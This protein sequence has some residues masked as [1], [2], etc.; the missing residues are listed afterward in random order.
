MGFHIALNHLVSDMIM[1]RC[2]TLPTPHC[3]ERLPSLVKERRERRK[4]EKGKKKTTADFP[5][6]ITVAR[7]AIVPPA[8]RA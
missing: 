1:L 5:S 8:K 3:N 6:G 7:Q 4:E 2:Q